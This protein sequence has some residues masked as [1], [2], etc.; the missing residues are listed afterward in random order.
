MPDNI[1]NALANPIIDMVFKIL[2][3]LVIP[4]CIWS[5]NQHYNCKEF[6]NKGDRFSNLDG[7][8]LEKEIIAN[9]QKLVELLYEK[10]EEFDE[11]IDN[12]PPQDWRKRIDDMSADIKR[13][14]IFVHNFE[15][16][17]TSDFIRKE[18]LELLLKNR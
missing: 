8:Y 18:E 5:T 13:V 7:V 4:W 17:F 9:N 15:R 6:M 2:M 3:V 10:L 12:L 1:K 11:R 14:D 16:T